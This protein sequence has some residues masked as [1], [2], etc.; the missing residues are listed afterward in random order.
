MKRLVRTSLVLGLLAVLFARPALADTGL[1]MLI[2]VWPGAVLLLIPVI[3]IE[4]LVAH[5]VLSFSPRRALGLA[6]KANLVSTIA[7][8]PLTWLVL[9]FWEFLSFIVLSAIPFERLPHWVETVCALTIMAPWPSG[10][11]LGEWGFPIQIA[12]LCVPF[13]FTS[14]YVETRVGKYVA[15]EVPEPA[16]QRWSIHAN[17]WSY[18]FIV[19]VLLALATGL[20][21]TQT[22]AAPNRA[23]QPIRSAVT[24]RAW[25]ASL[26]PAVG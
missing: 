9:V 12:V 21:F 10:S 4:A 20:W 18:G 15:P 22:A 2:V 7:G 14:V 6:T 11:G 16:M 26:Q 19:T 1:P 17:R 25:H 3:A 13:Y 23:L 8:I 24:P 5:K